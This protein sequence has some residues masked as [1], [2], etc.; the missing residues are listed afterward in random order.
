MS[1]ME[2]PTKKKKND[3]TSS[4]TSFFVANFLYLHLLFVDDLLNPS[5]FS[6]FPL[7]PFTFPNSTPLTAFVNGEGAITPFTLGMT[8][9]LIV[10]SSR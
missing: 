9:S 6:P 2:S 4:G 8:P 10:P 5:V 7:S 3:H 1:V